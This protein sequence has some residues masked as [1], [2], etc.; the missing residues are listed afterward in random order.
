M[1]TVFRKSF[2]L[3]AAS[4]GFISSV[5][6]IYTW[7]SSFLHFGAIYIPNP[8]VTII[9][10]LVA[11]LLVVGAFFLGGF[12]MISMLLASIIRAF[13]PLHKLPWYLAPFFSPPRPKGTPSPAQ[14]FLDQLKITTEA[15]QREPEQKYQRYQEPPQELPK[16]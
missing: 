1:K 10:V 15:Q 14:T 11:L 12:Y 2:G 5:F 9:A 6:G 7:M 16:Q 8:I 4:I 13:N 3:L